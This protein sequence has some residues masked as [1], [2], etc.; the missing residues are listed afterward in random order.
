MICPTFARPATRGEIYRVAVQVAAARKHRPEVAADVDAEPRLPRLLL[1]VGFL[2]HQARGAQ[3]GVSSLE[4]AQRAI[5]GRPDDLATAV[6]AYPGD[7]RERAAHAHQRLLVA[8]GLVEPGAAADVHEQYG[9]GSGDRGHGRWRPGNAAAQYRAYSRPGR[10][11]A[12]WRIDRLLQ[13]R[14]VL[15]CRKP[16]ILQEAICFLGA[17]AG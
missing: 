12:K 13:R 2:L 9:T 16:L 8:K 11:L 7:Q 5:A 4:H 3:G 1:L 15:N 10:V 14:L 17:I 6:L